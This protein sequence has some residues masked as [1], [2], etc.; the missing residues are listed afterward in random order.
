MKVSV[1]TH[2]K[3]EGGFYSDRIVKGILSQS[4][5]L[6]FGTRGQTLSRTRNKSAGCSELRNE[7]KNY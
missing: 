4:S 3:K 1:Q 7:R 5:G 6:Y 2:Y